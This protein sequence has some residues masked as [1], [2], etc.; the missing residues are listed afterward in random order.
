MQ[1]VVYVGRLFPARLPLQAPIDYVT[2]SIS[3]RPRRL[4]HAAR[5]IKTMGS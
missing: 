2:C 4:P 3:C 1:V 5:A